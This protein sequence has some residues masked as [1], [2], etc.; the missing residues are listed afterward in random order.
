[1]TRELELARLVRFYETLTPASLSGGLVQIYAADASFKDPFNDVR[2][3]AAIHAIFTHMFVT[4]PGARF[5][6]LSSAAQ[7]EQAFLIWE[8][9]LVLRG[10]PA[11]ICGATHILFDTQGL[12]ES[13]RDYWD[14]AEELYEKLPL[15]G[16]VLRWLKGLI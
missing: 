15:I 6:V 5:R 1:M 11:C 16:P 14:A 10:R 9:D 2:G 4:V 3:L 13:H 7:A 12:V 8:F